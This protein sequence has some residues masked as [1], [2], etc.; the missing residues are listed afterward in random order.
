MKEQKAIEGCRKQDRISQKYVYD[1]YADA[2]LLVCMRYVKPL[3][4]AEELMLNGFYNFFK[5]IDRF[6]YNGDGSVRPWLRKIMLNECLMHLRK[7][8]ELK[9]KPEAA[10]EGES[11]DP[12]VTGDMQAAE[13]LKL[14]SRLPPG[15]R[16][17]F[18]LYEVEGYSHKEIANLLNISEGT[19]KSQLSKARS[20]LQVM[21]KRQGWYN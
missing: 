13:L 20:Q 1:L 17:V 9:L 4:D 12:V 15:Y 19:S 7:T 3:P 5:N 18:N 16:T 2:M 8:G 21:V 10:G 6:I 11:V 14:I